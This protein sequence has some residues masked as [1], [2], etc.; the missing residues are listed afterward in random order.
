[1][2]GAGSMWIVRSLLTG[3]SFCLGETVELCV[4]GADAKLLADDSTAETMLT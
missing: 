3:E 1:K 2:P 4:D